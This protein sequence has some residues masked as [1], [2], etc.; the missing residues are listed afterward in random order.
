MREGGL[1]KRWVRFTRFVGGAAGAAML[2]TVIVVLPLPQGDIANA[3]SPARE[4]AR[5]SGVVTATTTTP[6]LPPSTVTLT[7]DRS[8]IE[9]GQSA[10]LTATVD[11][12][13]A[14]TAS[15]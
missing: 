9:A 2:A 3:A 8:V 1:V 10:T 15:V 13:L 14:N 11:Q 4:V 6:P 7:I 12:N 5:A